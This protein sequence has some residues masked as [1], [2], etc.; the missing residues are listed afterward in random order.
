MTSSSRSRSYNALLAPRS[1]ALIGASSNEA[2][3]TSRPMRFLK[4][5]G[6]EGQIF[7][8]NPGQS[9]IAGHACFADVSLTPEVPDHAYVL[10]D[11][12]S[13]LTAVEACGRAGITCVTV[14][15]D[16]FAEAGAEGQERQAKLCEIARRHDM[17]LI[18][19]NSTGVVNTRNGFAC[20]TNAAFAAESLPQGR[21]G[22]LSQS[23]SVIGAILSRAAAVGLGFGAYVS[24]GNEALS[25][26]GTLG[27]MMVD[28][29]EM[30][31]IVLFMETLRNRAAFVDFAQAAHA[32]GKPILAYLVGRSKAGGA[33][34]ASHT[35]AMT[36]GSHALEAFLKA[37]GVILVDG[38]E[39]LAE[40]SNA[41]P[42]RRRLAGR[43]RQVTVVTTTGGGGGMVY[44]R[45]GL[46]DVPLA[47][48]SDAAHAAI[49][50]V[51]TVI[52]PGPLVD[53]TLAG[54]KY[55][56][57]KAVMTGLT[58]D[59]NS[60]LIVAAIGSSAQF[61]PELAVKP[62]VDAVAEAGYDSSPVLAVP[63]PNAPESLAMFNAGGVP[64]CRSIEGAAEVVANLMQEPTFQPV[65]QAAL[66]EAVVQH[67]AAQTPG[68]MTETEAAAVFAALGVPGPDSLT[69]AGADD[70]PQ[71]LP[72]DGP[73][74]V[75][76]VSAD[77]LHKSDIGGVVINLA[78]REELVTAISDIAISVADAAPDAAITGYLIQKM[79]A[80]MGEAIVGLSRDPIAGPMITV[81]AG[82]VMTEIYR[83]VTSRPAPVS[84]ETAHA[85][86]DEVKSFALM[87][88]FR[89]APQGDLEALAAVV[90]Q[91]SRL[92]MNDRVTE[93]EINPVL[94]RTQGQGVVALDAL[95]SLS[96][97]HSKS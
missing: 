38:F 35:G 80:G 3:L 62:I 81:G 46:K 12:D 83:D 82:G 54:T 90:V 8:I 78:G 69:V 55:D 29:P 22:V 63:I 59:P 85:M 45:I 56:V 93:A 30:D 42:L 37:H 36:G 47:P 5:H 18:G 67:L 16:G 33:L 95:V 15:A 27:R 6:F 9:E 65:D 53:V 84:L 92:A 26:V 14:L 51:G 58:N 86:L 66:P 71:T 44:D 49:A 20:T 40:L 61:N 17:L 70:L 43:P 31:G 4:Q 79:E 87:R 34:A 25:D 68:T 11:S 10:L 77:I 19:P 48:M 72:F 28:D 39:A 41:L 94:V 91:V 89:G 24:L 88:G 97:D 21:F 74:A 13:A 75:K 2:K 52:K 76:V 96:D 60:G 1:V 57:M 73:Y 32:A 7:P 50:A 64:A 23:G